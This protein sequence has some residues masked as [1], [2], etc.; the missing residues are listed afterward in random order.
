MCVYITLYITCVGDVAEWRFRVSVVAPFGFV[1]EPPTPT[2][3]WGSIP[4]S[5]ED[6]HSLVCVV[7]ATWVVASTMLAGV[8]CAS[9]KL[10]RLGNSW[11]DVDE[12]L[13]LRG[14]GLLETLN[15][16]LHRFQA[17]QNIP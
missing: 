13:G 3:T 7:S 1:A 14:F 17:F 15:L 10:R 16:H 6:V 4:T 12:G 2:W 11:N 5:F 9:L 8:N